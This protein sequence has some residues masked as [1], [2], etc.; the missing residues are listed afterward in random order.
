MK[1][2]AS[3]TDFRR[4]LRPGDAVEFFFDMKDD[5]GARRAAGRAALHVHHQRRA[6]R[7]R[8]YRFRTPDGIVDY[9][10]EKGSNSQQVPDAPPG[11]RRGRAPHLGLRHAPPSAPER[12]AHAHRRRLGDA[13]GTPDPRRRQ[14]RHR[15]GR[16]QGPVR[17]LHPHPPRQRLPDRLRALLRFA[18]GHRAGR[19][20][21]AGRRSSATSA[22]PGLAR[23]RTCTSRCWST[24]ASSTRSASRS[25]A[26]A[27]LD[28]AGSSPISR[29][30]APASTTCAT[31][32]P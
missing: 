5:A 20:G 6:R 26:S 23:V 16:P 29:R 27:K 4:R 30:S 22:R 10:D 21:A 8:F 19:Q 3:E 13:P 14:R 17:Q 9:Y 2:H 31:S 7:K 1:I 18:E 11:A 32:R 15:G 28:R 12:A 25:R 24:A